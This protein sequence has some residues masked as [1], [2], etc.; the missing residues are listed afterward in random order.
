MLRVLLSVNMYALGH[1]RCV[2]A[3]HVTS[4]NDITYLLLTSSTVYMCEHACVD[5]NCDDQ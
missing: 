3:H 4:L 5:I 2:V 1:A